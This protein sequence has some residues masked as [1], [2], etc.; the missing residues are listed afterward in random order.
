[1]EEYGH[2]SK[3]FRKADVRKLQD[4]QTPRAR[5]DNLLEPEA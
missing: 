2:E 3:T 4:H 5:D 1:L